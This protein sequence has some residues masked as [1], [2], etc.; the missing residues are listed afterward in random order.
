MITETV[1]YQSKGTEC[2]GYLACS[3]SSPTKRPAVLIAHAWRGQ[4]EFARQKARDLA[5]L[6]YVGFAADLYGHGK[7]AAD[8]DEAAKLMRP[9]FLDR[10][11]L[12]DR[13]TAA[14]NVLID[15]PR[16]NADAIGAIGF[17][18]GGL[19]VIELLRSGA[20][21]SGVVSFHGMLGNTLGEHKAKT[22]ADA[23]TIRGALL[24]L[25]GHKDPMTS[26]AEIE[27]VQTEFTKA[28]IDWQMITY[29]LATHA[30]TNPMANEE[31]N[32][33][34]YHPQTAFRAWQAMINFFEEIFP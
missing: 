27:S 1:R 4:D 24:I 8:N 14:L 17:C 22:V 34:L 5:D 31:K 32:G 20:P 28:G 12:L 15:H 11:L 6:G 26:K 25:H 7:N 18:F 29:G 10:R 2:L 3:D 21:V 23:S 19:T 16:V 30:F 9:L 33:L 13:I